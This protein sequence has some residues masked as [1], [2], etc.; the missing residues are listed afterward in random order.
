MSIGSVQ[1]PIGTLPHP[2]IRLLPLL[3]LRLTA[4]AP[5]TKESAPTEREESRALSP[6]A[7]PREIPVKTE[8][9]PIDKLCVDNEV[10]DVPEDNKLYTESDKRDQ[11][12]TSRQDSGTNP[13]R[14][15][16]LDKMEGAPNLLEPLNPCP[17]NVQDPVQPCKLDTR[18]PIT[19]LGL[20]GDGVG[21]L[22]PRKQKIRG[23]RLVLVKRVP[24]LSSQVPFFSLHI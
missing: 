22:K 18:N 23:G 20:N 9:L 2:P 8:E 1:C 4:P 24:F 13:E 6:K 19:G 7:S 5:A 10:G 17:D 16:S 12:L 14:P 21:G 3:P 11:A 15:Y